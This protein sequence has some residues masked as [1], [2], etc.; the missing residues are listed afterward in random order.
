MHDLRILLA[1]IPCL[2]AIGF[3]LYSIDSAKEFFS[4]RPG[5]AQEFTPA[6]SILKPLR[7]FEADAY[8]NLASFC[9]QDYPAYQILFG[10]SDENDPCIEVVKK[11]IRD[12][13]DRDIQLLTCEPGMAANPKVGSLIQMAARAKYPL[14]L[15]SDSDIRVGPDYLKRV[16]RPLQDP[17][18][19]A[20]TCMGRSRTRG[21]PSILEALR[22]STDF[23]PGVLVA[24]RLEG[25]RFALGSTIAVRR[26]LLR[27]LGGFEIISDYLADDF[28]LGCLIARAGY[29]VVLS[30]YVVEHS[31]QYHD[32]KNILQRQIRWARGIRVSRPWG[33]AGLLLTQGTVMG[34]VFFL[35]AGGTALAWAVLGMTW[36]SRLAMAHLVGSRYLRDLA[37]KRYLWLVPV[38]DLLSFSVWCGC[39]FGSRIAWRDER[40][41]LTKTG[42]LV[43]VKLGVPPPDAA[44]AVERS[45]KVAVE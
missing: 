35:L 6:V 45:V 19:G 39:F 43:P 24:R 10:V 37:A 11:I 29:Q 18:V 36:I 15:I 23:L 12:F 14:Y 25:V 16:I 1:L 32:F 7:G 5:P 41:T 42:K 2:T 44:E 38:Q 4:G 3:Y 31:F 21:L 40:F 20:V 8:G 34:L 28:Q 9:V 13:P 17:K 22:V 33:Y 26:D 27:A 30:D